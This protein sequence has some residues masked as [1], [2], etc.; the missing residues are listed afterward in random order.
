MLCTSCGGKLKEAQ[1]FCGG[2]G[3]KVEANIPKAGTGADHSVMIAPVKLELPTMPIE[4]GS[5]RIEGPDGDGNFSIMVPCKFKNNSKEDWH[6]L[7]IRAHLL[8]SDGVILQESTDTPEEL[9]EASAV[10]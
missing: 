8:N 9:I 3:A 1:K 5:V 2:C 6:Y 4:I 10:Y 7:E